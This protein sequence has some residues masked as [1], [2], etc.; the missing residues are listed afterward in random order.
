M[1]YIP[2]LARQNANVAGSASRG[3]GEDRARTANGH[4]KVRDSVPDLVCISGTVG[5]ARAA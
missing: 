3:P 1:D 2:L 5:R 4:A